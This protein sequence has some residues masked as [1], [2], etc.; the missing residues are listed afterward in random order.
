MELV[1]NRLR[2]KFGYPMVE[3][4]F[5]SR[6]GPHFPEVLEKCVN[7]GAESVVV[8][9]YFLHMGL[10]GRG[11]GFDELL[12]DIIQKRIQETRDL[13]DVRDLVLPPKEQYPV[14][15]G[16]CEFVPMLP[17]EAARYRD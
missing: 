15:P 12:V 10:F 5:M 4:C 6:L 11:F 8:I 3:V 17:E 7:Q 2:Q 1:A 16:Q 14:P 13:D 9:P